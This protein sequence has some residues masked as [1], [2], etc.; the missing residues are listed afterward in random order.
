ME[1]YPLKSIFTYVD[2]NVSPWQPQ[3]RDIITHSIERS[4]GCEGHI[5]LFGFSRTDFDEVPENDEDKW[6]VLCRAR[7]DGTAATAANYNELKYV[8]YSELAG[9]GKPDACVANCTKSIEKNSGVIRL[10]HFGNNSTD[11]TSTV[12]LSG[13]A[14][15]SHYAKNT[16]G[17][18]TQF[19]CRQGGVLK[20]ANL[21]LVNG[22]AFRGN[23]CACENEWHAGMQWDLYSAN[24]SNVQIKVENNK[25]TIGVYYV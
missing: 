10:Y 15:S 9:G 24:D 21:N 6:G 18:N 2:N 16:D 11:F 3:P 7:L 20:Y 13:Y 12:S 14:S 4:E 25:L 1:Y 8:K 23:H 17:S 5:R 19:L 22:V